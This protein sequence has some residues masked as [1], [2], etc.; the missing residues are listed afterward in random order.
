MKKSWHQKNMFEKNVPV[1]YKKSNQSYLGPWCSHTGS[2]A[3]GKTPWK[4]SVRARSQPAG[5]SNG[6]MAW[7]ANGSPSKSDTSSRVG[8]ISPHLKW[9]VWVSGLQRSTKQLSKDPS[10]ATHFSP[11]ID[12]TRRAKGKRPA[13]FNLHQR[14]FQLVS[15]INMHV[16]VQI[17]KTR[18]AEAILSVSSSFP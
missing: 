2:G 6:P 13:H 7:P 5:A 15:P 1:P 8:A 12:S 3:S 9:N 14:T 18:T 4:R 10:M 11:G 16:S 17:N